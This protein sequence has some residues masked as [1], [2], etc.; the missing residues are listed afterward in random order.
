M[1]AV[2]HTATALS[3]SAILAAPVAASGRTD[4]MIAERPD[5]AAVFEEQGTS[6][7]FVLYVEARRPTVVNRPRA[8]R[9]RSAGA[10]CIA[11][12]AASSAG[13]RSDNGYW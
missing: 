12:K 1:F 3:L 13:C 8:K 4:E 2:G 9:R 5:I 7:I 6:G 11:W 10:S